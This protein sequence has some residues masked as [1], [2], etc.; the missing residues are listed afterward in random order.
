MANATQSQKSDKKTQANLTAART[1]SP[2][3]TQSTAEPFALQAAAADPLVA[4]SQSILQLQGRYGNRAVQRLIQ[5]AQK[6]PGVGQQ[7]GEI[8][9]D[10]QSQIS[11]AQGGGRPLDKTSSHKVGTALNSDFSNVRVHTDSNAD[12]LNQSLNASAFTLGSDVFFSKGAYEPGTQRGQKL[13]AHELTHVVQQG[14]V[15]P[16][17]VQTKLVVGAAGDKYEEEAD[18]VAQGVQRTPLRL[19]RAP[20][21]IQ[22]K[23][24]FTGA[25]ET[26]VDIHAK[27]IPQMLQT[28]E[29][30]DGI[31]ADLQ[32]KKG[33]AK[34]IEADKGKRVENRTIDLGG[35]TIPDLSKDEPK[36]R[37][38]FTRS[39]EKRVDA[40][41]IEFGKMNERARKTNLALKE[42]R[43]HPVF[44][45]L[46][47]K[48]EDAKPPEKQET[49]V[50]DISGLGDFKPKKK[51]EDTGNI[52]NRN[53]HKKVMDQGKALEQLNQ[54]VRANDL[55]VDELS[56]Y[57]QK[58]LLAPKL[59]APSEGDGGKPKPVS[60]NAGRPLPPRPGSKPKPNYP[61]PQ[62]PVKGNAV[63]TPVKPKPPEPEPPLPT[64]PAAT[65][66][67]AKIRFSNNINWYDKSG[68]GFVRTKQTLPKGSVL[69]DVRSSKDP[70][71][72]WAITQHGYD[73]YLHTENL[74]VHRLSSQPPPNYIDENKLFKVA[75]GK[76]FQMLATNREWFLDQAVL[77]EAF[78][79]LE[80]V[81]EATRKQLALVML[82][83]F[84]KAA[85]VDYKTE[86]DLGVQTTPFD[87]SRRAGYH[88]SVD[89]NPLLTKVL[90]TFVS[91]I[92]KGQDKQLD[93]MALR[94]VSDPYFVQVL[95][96]KF[97]IFS[98][99][100]DLGDLEAIDTHIDSL[101]KFKSSVDQLFTH[102]AAGH[103]PQGKFVFDLTTFVAANNLTATQF[104]TVT[105]PQLEREFITKAGAFK[106]SYPEQANGLTAIMNGFELVAMSKHKGVDV[107][108]APPF[109]TKSSKSKGEYSEEEAGLF[110]GVMGGKHEFFM[111]GSKDKEGTFEESLDHAMVES[112]YRM[113]PTL[114]KQALLEVAT[115]E[116]ALARAGAGGTANIPIAS[117]GTRGTKAPKVCDNIHAFINMGIVKRFN[118]LAQ[119]DEAPPYLKIYPPA[120]FASLEGLAKIKPKAVPN[121]KPPRPPRNLP[122]D[123]KPLPP[124]KG[125]ID[126]V[127]TEK[128]IPDVLQIAYFRILNSMGAAVL[129]Q[130]DLVKFMNEIEVIHQQI[131]MIL[132]IVQ[133]YT[134]GSFG[135]G[136]KAIMSQGKDGPMVPEGLGT[137]Q[138]HHK[139]SAMHGLASILSSTE[140]QKGGNNLNVVA[141]EDN[142]YEASM[143][144]LAQAKTYNVD[145]L[146]GDK[147]R[148]KEQNRV[149]LS[150][151]AFE[152]GKKPK[153]PVDIYVADFHHNISLNR[154]VY[155]TE[156]LQH[157]VNEL[158]NAGLV[159]DKFTVA[160]DCTIDFID[161]EDIRDFLKQNEAR[162][163]GGQMNV[164]LYRSAQKFDMLGLDNYYGGFTISINN[165][166]KYDAFNQRMS[167]KEDQASGIS[168]QGMAHLAGNAGEHL[169]KYRAALMESTMRVYKALPPECIYAEGSESP[170]Q[171]SKIE[172]PRSVFLDIKF[173]PIKTPAIANDVGTAISDKIFAYAA[174]QGLALTARASFG[175]A[176]SNFTK[177][178]GTKVRLN[179]G[180]EGPEAMAKYARFFTM[181]QQVMVVAQQ[182]GRTQNMSGVELEKA[183]LLALQSL[184]V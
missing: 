83:S 120:T 102:A 110:D 3:P 86:E 73:G 172:D 31:V 41:N 106:K 56:K 97:P 155:R 29:Y 153:A 167:A 94:L 18:A 78:R 4:S 131:Q 175:F 147:L 38:L 104:V 182:K 135:E 138:V 92:N 87:P 163:K 170:M 174:S 140:E 80:G 154:N 60:K 10:L 55:Y 37:N 64:T 25:L 32:S 44:A 26:K 89:N 90:D 123:V 59:P 24:L 117:L 103:L 139:A 164:V 111:A 105:T 12:Q 70:K 109:L 173:P 165:S 39:L 152:G 85:S 14:G 177:I 42:L 129:Y 130:N 20:A 79:S 151:D 124:A 181:V 19:N 142:Y 11:A 183:M 137:P 5:R 22:R 178:G 77:M 128:K 114:A 184:P 101:E 133:P 161:S 96:R 61:P 166:E 141:L 146:K 144:A 113:D 2:N 84:S 148:D 7:G 46:G 71:F 88:R 119:K 15:K 48:I 95:A 157:Q 27:S 68:D 99:K 74:D 150:D 180:L 91:D 107:L 122:S 28:M 34:Q 169:D 112:G 63:Q 145:V 93:S 72:V 40:L 47:K 36:Y 127:F 134:S 35:L 116:E 62:P 54:V 69:M 21:R 149:A 108:L 8:D 43:E 1:V 16:N 66:K 23:G 121:G 9:D 132:A 33:L 57:Y 53:V 51:K 75:P 143:Y 179:P 136:I 159:A 50:V 30:A 52:I 160:I 13:L 156:D 81:D 82:N 6:Q 67:K 125:G 176:T 126:E 162:I 49:R 76:D 118:A 168:A 115:P 100:Q 171:I 17:K 58:Q 98:A 45:E 65:V 158:F